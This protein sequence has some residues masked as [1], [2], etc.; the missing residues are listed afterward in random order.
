MSN[1]I[2]KE[3]NFSNFTL[4]DEYS[5]HTSLY[6][7]DTDSKNIYNVDIP[8]SIYEDGY[9][10]NCKIQN[11]KFVPSNVSII[12]VDYDVYINEDGEL[13]DDFL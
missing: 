3:T 12:E 4:Y 2:S 7:Y 1:V 10:Y 5:T 11:V 13:N 6:V 9:G 8:Y